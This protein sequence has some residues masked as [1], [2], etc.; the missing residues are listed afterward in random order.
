[1]KHTGHREVEIGRVNSIVER[2]SRNELGSFSAFAFGSTH[3]PNIELIARRLGPSVAIL[4][5]GPSVR[6]LWR[7]IPLPKPRLFSFQINDRDIIPSILESLNDY[8][9]IS[10]LLVDRSEKILPKA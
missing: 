4:H 1:M 10:F 7:L 3:T 2:L 6:G 8:L 9:L 5:E